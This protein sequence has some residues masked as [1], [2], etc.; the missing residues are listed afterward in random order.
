M[1]ILV[2]Q[3]AGVTAP[4]K[5]RLPRGHVRD[6]WLERLY[7]AA[8]DFD[9]LSGI[10]IRRP[11]FHRWEE[12]VH[13]RTRSPLAAPLF[14]QVPPPANVPAA[15]TILLTTPNHVITGNSYEQITHGHHRCGHLARRRSPVSARLPP[16]HTA[17]RFQY[18]CNAIGASISCD[19]ATIPGHFPE[20]ELGL[21]A[22]FCAI[23]ADLDLRLTNELCEL[24]SHQKPILS[25]DFAMTIA[26]YYLIRTLGLGPRIDG[27]YF[28]DNL[29]PFIG[30]TAEQTAG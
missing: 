19:S 16:R 3:L 4:D 9:R 18:S 27:R 24:D 10:V 1:D 25:D 20:Q 28:V 17:I 14:Q 21:S 6:H 5:S 29:V 22:F 2:A 26:I 7:S 8:D 12:G 11:W 30:A 13:H 23:T 15:P